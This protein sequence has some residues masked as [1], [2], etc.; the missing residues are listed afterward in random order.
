VRDISKNIKRSNGGCRNTMRHITEVDE[1]VI[2]THILIHPFALD[3]I[4]PSITELV[5]VNIRIRTRKSAGKRKIF[6]A[7]NT[8]IEVMSRIGIHLI[9]T[10]NQL[11]EGCVKTYRLRSRRMTAIDFRSKLF[12]VICI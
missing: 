8:I 7:S 11:P 1:V 3:S 2:N 12:P 5:V 6:S 9:T 4:I 10:N